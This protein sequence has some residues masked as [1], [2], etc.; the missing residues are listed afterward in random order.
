MPNTYLNRDLSWLGFNHRVLLE[1]ANP[2]VP[3][4]ER[5]KFLAIFSSN[6][7]EFF[8]VRMSSL[9]SLEGQYTAEND[10]TESSFLPQ[11][12]AQV[13]RSQQEFGR[14]IT[15]EILPEL[16]RQ[17][18]HLYYGEPLRPEHAG[19]VSAYFFSHLL[20][21]L[22][23]VWLNETSPL[24]TNVPD[25]A[26]YMAV[27][28][29]TP[30]GQPCFAVVNIPD[31]NVPRFLLL[32]PAADGTQHIAFIDDLMRAH[33]AALFPGYGVAGCYSVKLTRNA[34]VS[35]KDE[36]AGEMDDNIARMLEQR[37]AGHT[38]RF[39]YDPAIPAALLEALARAFGLLPKALVSGGRYHNLSSLMSLPNPI[40]ASLTY[41]P[42]PPQPV[43]ALQ[44]ETSL[45]DQLDRQDFLLSTPYQSYNPVLRF[46]NEAA[47]NPAVT[48][49]FVTLYRIASDSAIGHALISAAR[50]GKRVTVFVEL[51]AR[52]DEA[53][54]LKWSKRFKAAGIRLVYSIPKLK[55][56][57]KVALV[58]RQVGNKTQQ[59]ALLSTGNF[60]ENTARFYTDHTLLTSHS[61]LCTDLAALVTYLQTRTQPSDY[62]P[63]H[64]AHLLVAQYN[65]M[66]HFM[67]LID[68][69]IANHRAG[70]PAHITLKMN[71]LQE[72]TMVDALYKASRAGVSID[73]IVRGICVLIPGVAGQ[74]ETIRVRRIV[75]RYLEHSRIFVFHNAGQSE[76]Y[77]G[78]ADWMNRNLHRRIEVC[79][80]VYTPA[81]RTQLWQQLQAQLADNQQAT[82]LNTDTE[83]VFVAAGSTPLRAQQEIYETVQRNAIPLNIK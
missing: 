78:S 57:A 74:S 42:Q 43:A 47:T 15:T 63:V 44:S 56:H 6:L 10:E 29:T 61:G 45:F 9:L 20:A 79:F 38:T 22:Q 54:N 31:Q 36:F 82:E 67:A 55:V 4:Y 77:L 32:P 69:E 33:M 39:L 7:D 80:P 76:T 3:I 24:A 46:F 58:R 59:Y 66:P 81:L 70:L 53:N 14:L 72:R 27:S 50:N 11:I 64:F 40:G 35:I 5:V 1:A 19:A 2:N 49:V 23:P 68:R 48:E 73:L 8:R 52:F 21:H 34:D 18:I 26:L 16:A 75:D 71:N 30:D 12:Q 62:P 17:G 60:N 13:R 25:S 51:K 41:P 65:L 83:W 28:L 37:K